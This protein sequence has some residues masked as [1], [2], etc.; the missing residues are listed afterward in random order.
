MNFNVFQRMID[1]FID[2]K[3]KSGLESETSE[4]SQGVVFECNQG[5]KRS[6]DDLVVDVSNTLFGPVLYLC[7]IDVVEKSVDGEISP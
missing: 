2:R 7:C 1:E 5:V 4:N 6:S 3:I